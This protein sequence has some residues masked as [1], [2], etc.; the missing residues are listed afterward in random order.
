MTDS[1]SK[2]ANKFFGKSFS[3][4]GFPEPYFPI[5]TH[6]LWPNSSHARPYL[7]VSASRSHPENILRL[8]DFLKFWTEWLRNIYAVTALIIRRT[9]TSFWFL[10]YSRTIRQR[11]LPRGEWIFDLTAVWSLDPQSS[12]WTSSKATHTKHPWIPQY[13]STV[14][15]GHQ[16][17]GQTRQCP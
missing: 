2:I 4:I 17:F 14:I 3:I 5:V 6:D 10:P 16:S 13:A 1:A 7:A 12:S 15:R 11:S 9:A 8:I